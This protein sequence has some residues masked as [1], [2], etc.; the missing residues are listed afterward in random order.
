MIKPLTDE[1]LRD[2]FNR[3]NDAGPLAEGWPG[4]ERFAREVERMVRFKHLPMSDR[5][6]LKCSICGKLKPLSALTSSIPIICAHGC[7][8]G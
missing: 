8:L 4:L 5:Y 7:K 3:T 1:E 6:G 2:A